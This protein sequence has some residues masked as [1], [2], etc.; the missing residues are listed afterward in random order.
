MVG[1]LI[2]ILAAFQAT[3]A[4]PVLLSQGKTASASSVQGGNTAANGNDGSTTTR[5]AANSGTFPQWWKV[6]LGVSNSLTNVDINWYSSSSRSYKYKIEV[7]TDD[8]TYTTKVDKTSNTTTG[9]TSDS[10]TA[11]ARYVR[12]TITGCS[13]GGAYSSAYEFKVYGG[14]IGITPTVTPTLG[15][16]A[17]PTATPTSGPTATPTKTVTSTPTPTLPPVTGN[18]ALNKSCNASSTQNGGTLATYAVDGNTTTRWSS[19]ALDPQWFCVD[20]GAFYSI[21]K[22]V[23]RWE[24]AYAKAYQIQ[25]TNDGMNWSTVYS[26]TSGPGGTET[27]NFT[28]TTGRFIRIYGTQ[29]GTQYGYSLYEFEVY[30]SGPVAPPTPLPTAVPPP[31]ATPAQV[32]QTSMYGDRL[33]V[34]P[35]LYLVNDDGSSI[36]TITINSTQTYQTIIGFGG[37]FTESSAYV[38]SKIS[39]AKRSEILNAYFSPSGSNYTLCR[40]HINSCDFSLS[41]YSY[42]DTAG[43]TS[44]NN[45]NIAH[46]TTLLIPLIK[47]SMALQPAGIKI[48]SSPWSPPAW[49]KT[50]GTMNGG[51]PLLTQYY[52][53]WALY[54]SKYIKAYAAQ[55]INIWGIT[56]QN[57]P[58]NWP[59]WEGCQFSTTQMRDF[60]KNNLGPQLKNDSATNAVNIMIFDHNKGEIVTWANDILS[61]SLAASYAW[62]TAFHWYGD[63]NFGNLT[64]VHNS[65]PCKHLVHTEGCQEGG[66]HLYEWAPAER[67]G[68]KMMG[69]LNN[70]TEGWVDWNIVLDQQGGPNHV[71]NFC[72]AP[73]HCDLT[74]GTVIY[75]PSYYYITQI[76]RYVKPGA[77]RIGWSSNATGL[78]LT[79]FKN[80]DGKIVVIVMNNSV[81]AISFKI[82]N[83]TQMIKPTLPNNTIATYIF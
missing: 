13:A 53:A 8:T 65:F 73:I 51:S 77:V 54:F 15:P 52:P 39:A 19:A 9:D 43:D 59:S 74:K 20:L 17:T 47:D 4:A 1:L 32:I 36:P 71:N 29:R 22:V 35:N 37:A 10:F 2:V 81:N 24:S 7:S 61:D 57:E 26:T 34:K 67:Y 45:F 46:D 12:I 21:N 27:L 79:A 50:N 75:N 72:S 55:G 70:W 14:S 64:T 33:T 83:G 25:I 3:S 62:G 63:D 18:L 31:G 42:D 6:D 68:H 49:M 30:G 56:I 38:L 16:T 60:L 69:D 80:P 44:L 82:K 48:F 23:L 5:W 40:T 41:N 78:E 66:P 58:M 28:A 76:S 11:V